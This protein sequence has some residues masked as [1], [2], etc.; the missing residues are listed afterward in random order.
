MTEQEFLNL[1]AKLESN[2]LYQQSTSLHKY[3]QYQQFDFAGEL[4]NG[5]QL[6]KEDSEGIP[7]GEENYNLLTSRVVIYNFT[8]GVLNSENNE[9][10]VQYPSHWEIWKNGEIVKVVSDGGDIE[11]YWENGVPVRIERNLA[12]RRNNGEQI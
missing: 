4:L 11:E 5:S 9:P 3:M 10:A 7:E 6:R 2:E 12:E 1:Q 8:D